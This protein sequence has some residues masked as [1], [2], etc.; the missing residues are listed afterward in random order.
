MGAWEG[1][2]IGNLH[3]AVYITQSWLRGISSLQSPV[4]SLQCLQ[5]TVHSRQSAVCGLHS[6]LLQSALCNLD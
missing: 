4:S 2:P 3:S 5:S 1:C 6:G